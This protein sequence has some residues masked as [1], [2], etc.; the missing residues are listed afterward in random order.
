MVVIWQ[1][2]LSLQDRFLRGKGGAAFKGK[3]KKGGK[4]G[5]GT[6]SIMISSNTV[7]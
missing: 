7:T 6:P 2:L 5:V 3:G 4:K 1:N